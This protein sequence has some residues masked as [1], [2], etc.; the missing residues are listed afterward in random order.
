MKK[1]KLYYML[2]FVFMWLF[3]LSYFY[4]NDRD[5]LVLFIILP[6]LL[7]VMLYISIR[8][9]YF[10]LTVFLSL[11]FISQAINPAFFFL[12]RENYSYAGWNAIKD[13]NFDLS[14]FYFIYK[15]MYLLL[16]FIFIFTLFFNKLFNNSHRLMIKK[17]GTIS[18]HRVDISEKK[19]LINKKIGNKDKYSL[20]IFLV[21]MFLAIPLNIFMY[22]NGIGISTIDPQRLPFKLV[23]IT[24]YLRNYIIPTII[25]YLYYKSKRTNL[26]TAFILLYSILVGILSLSKGNILLTILPVVL[27]S[28]ID[29]KQMRLYFSC[30]FAIFLYLMVSWARQFVFISSIGSVEMIGNIFSNIIESDFIDLNFFSTFLN[31]ISD[32][33]YGAQSTVLAHQYSLDNNIY[34]TFNFLIARTDNLSN[35]ILDDLFMLHFPDG[36]TFGVGIGYLA[37]LILLANKN[38]FM[39]IFL[40]L[41]TAIYL[42][43]SEIII[44]K[45]LSTNHL[46]NLLGYPLGFFL[47][48]FLYDSFMGKFYFILTLS[49]MGLLLLKLAPRS[50][51]E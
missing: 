32:R 23:G 33:L 25:T 19:L 37:T 11:A 21:I 22:K 44:S 27:F 6:P 4:A 47:V 51:N 31:A 7:G 3:L 9:Q 2:P 50:H 5:G 45:Y 46:I 18:F 30:L 8:K 35:I 40:S 34:E 16:F 39:M 17:R 38:L 42:T 15:D 43:V 29:K 48:F 1:Q 36:V 24:F 28:V 10:V 49:A 14:E 26:S 12:N 13:F 41:V 20:Y